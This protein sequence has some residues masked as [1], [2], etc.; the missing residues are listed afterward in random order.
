[1]LTIPVRQ[2]V[3]APAEIAAEDPGVV[4]ASLN[5]VIEKIYVKPNQQVKQGQK[6]FSLDEIVL[7]NDFEESMKTLDV[8][9]EKYRRAYQHAYVKKENKAQI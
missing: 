7:Q 8:T 6:L 2:T 4:S 9:R 1:M 5:G 3:L